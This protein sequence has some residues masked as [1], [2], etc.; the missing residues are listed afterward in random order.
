MLKI[1]VSLLVLLVT[2]SGCAT[3]KKDDEPPPPVIG[4]NDN[5]TG[6][7]AIPVTFEQFARKTRSSTGIAGVEEARYSTL[8]DAAV[9]YSAQAAYERRT[10]E[11]LRELEGQ[12]TALSEEFNFNN[13]VYSTPKQAGYVIPPVVTCAK[14]AITITKSG[15]ESVAADEYYR[16]EQPGRIVGVIPTWRDYLVMQMDKASNPEEQ[17]LPSDKEE[18]KIWDKFMAEGWRQGREQA[19]EALKLNM[20]LLRRDYLGMIEYRRLVDA[21]LIRSLMISSSEVRA[22]GTVNELFI[23]Q[24]RVRIENDASFV[25]NPRKWKP[26]TRRFEIS[27]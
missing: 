12:S 14:E 27:K 18:R 11:I 19:E 21:G 9:G 15:R 16:I 7:A 4:G 10:W 5:L 13:V 26:V 23:G 3:P 22:K 24:R 1:F 20:N 8:R 25:T 6:A 2:V 17:F